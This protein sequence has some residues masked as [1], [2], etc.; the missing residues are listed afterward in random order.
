MT[1][2]AGSHV[3][4]LLD[5]KTLITAYPILTVSGGKGAQIWLTYSEA[6]Y[7]EEMHK[8]DRDEVGDR[9]AHGL[10]DSFLPDGGKERI[11]EPLWWR[12]WRYL[13]LEIQTAGEPL[14]LDSLHAQFTA[15]PFKQRATFSPLMRN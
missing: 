8:G 1:V 13:D 14:T 15:Y 10:K 7:D 11:F 5:R 2:P 12:T 9:T 4:I 6:L 3:H